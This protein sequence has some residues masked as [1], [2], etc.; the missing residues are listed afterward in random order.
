MN[1][2]A[3][4]LYKKIGLN[5]KN[6][7]KNLS[8]TQDGLGRMI[9]LTRASIA[10]IEAGKQGILLDTAISIT[11]ALECDLVDL[12]GSLDNQLAKKVKNRLETELQCKNEILEKRKK[13]I[14]QEQK[15]ILRRLKGRKDHEQNN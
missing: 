4:E 12:I 13:R 1:Y 14:E 9:Y 5:I 15:N 2:N 8:L 3:R 7:R 10:N 6:R 11:V